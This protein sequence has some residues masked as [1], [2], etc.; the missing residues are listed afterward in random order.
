MLFKTHHFFWNRVLVIFS[1]DFYYTHSKKKSIKRGWK[2]LPGWSNFKWKNIFGN[3]DVK[4]KQFADQVHLHWCKN[5]TKP[6]FSTILFFHIHVIKKWN[7]LPTMSSNTYRM[8]GRLKQ[9]Q[10]GWIGF[11]ERQVF[12][13]NETDGA[14]N[15]NC[16]R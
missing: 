9:I 14:D 13:W 15:N 10:L 7:F 4:K 16:F 6:A 8:E 3:K 12:G 2:I 1:Q 11:L 5:S